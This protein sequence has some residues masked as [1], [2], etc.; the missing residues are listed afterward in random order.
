MK[1]LLLT[2]GIFL[3]LT[4]LAFAT[5]TT[6]KISY[7]T[8]TA[9]TCSL[10][11]GG[12][13]LASSATVGRCST[14]VDNTTNLFDD[15]IVTV[16]IKTGSGSMA[17]DKAVYIYVY[18]SEDGTNYEEEES[19]SPATDGSYTINAPTIFRGPIV[20]PVLTAAKIYTKVF[21][22]ANMFGGVMPRKWGIIIINFTGQALDTTEANH[23][24]SY[25]GIYYTNQ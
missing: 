15:A 9:I 19:N 24:K 10:A 22:V 1:K 11:P 7:G 12:T 3:L 5:T 17:N 25:T 18:G 6:D 23:I 16:S 14:A 20:I 21:T 4:S 8:S 2:L 13:G